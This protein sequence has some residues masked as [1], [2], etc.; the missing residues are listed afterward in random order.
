RRARRNVLGHNRTCPGA[1]AIANGHWSNQQGIAS[2]EDVVTD[3]GAVLVDAIEVAGHGAGADVDVG[4]QAGIADVAK[5]ADPDA[6]LHAGILEL[7]EVA[8]VDACTD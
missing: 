2:D 8:D 7:C 3:L 5:M 6:F 1:S 4:P